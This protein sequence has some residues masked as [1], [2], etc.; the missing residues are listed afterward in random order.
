[1][2]LCGSDEYCRQART[3]DP[4]RSEILEFRRPACGPGGRALRAQARHRRPGRD[5]RPAARR[6][7]GRRPRAARGRA[8]PGEDADLKTLA[9]ARRQFN[10]VQFTPDLVPAD[11]V[12]THVFRP[13]PAVRTELGP[14]FGNFLL[15]D[16]INRAPAKCRRAARGHA[17][18]AGDDR[19]PALP[20]AGAVPRHRDAEPDRVR[21]H[22]SAARSAARPLP[23]Q[24]QRRLPDRRGGGR[25][26]GRAMAPPP[27][28]RGSSVADLER[29]RGRAK[30]V[31]WPRVSATP[32]S[33]PTPRAA[34]ATASHD[35]AADR[36]RRQPARPSVS[37]RPPRR[38]R[39]CAAATT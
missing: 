31:S 20:A 21:G 9:R 16:E 22:L 37:S 30:R 14:V 3:H 8:G 19:R 11:I 39:C 7:P 28:A 4:E 34:R 10:R 38:S 35:R 13:A 32:S 23:V 36:V 6:A 17:G 33:S 18:A 25:G 29:Y 12:G 5:A 1:M 27:A 2:K 15:A 24:A 26:V